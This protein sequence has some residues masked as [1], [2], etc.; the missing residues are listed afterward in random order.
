MNASGK[1]I[2]P[3][4]IG[5]RTLTREEIEALPESLLDLTAASKVV[6]VYGTDPG[7]IERGR[8]VLVGGLD[9]DVRRLVENWEDRDLKDV[10]DAVVVGVSGPA[11]SKGAF[12]LKRVL[13]IQIDV[14]DTADATAKLV[15]DLVPEDTFTMPPGQAAQAA[16][17]AERLTKIGAEFGYLNAAQVA[18]RAGHTAVNRSATATRWRN[19]RR[20]VG[21]HV[22][23]EWRYPAFQFDQAGQPLPIIRDLIDVYEPT[24]EYAML[25]W[26]TAPNGYLD[27]DRPVD[28]LWDNPQ[29]VLDTALAAR[30]PAET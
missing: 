10:Q 14:Q 29:D 13:N 3:M 5:Q 21:V 30:E 8:V 4:E 15:S 7:V 25:A 1:R 2:A 17:A 22:K 18:D 27:G 16:L 20:I 28:L 19:D 11:V 23:G 24:T 6:M 9:A 26:L 12:T